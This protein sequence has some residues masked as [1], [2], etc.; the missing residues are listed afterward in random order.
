LPNA[1]DDVA[2]LSFAFTSDLLDVFGVDA[3]SFHVH[4]DFLLL[5]SKKIGC[6][7]D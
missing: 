1:V 4:V 3:D 7:T 2:A 6:P 5:H